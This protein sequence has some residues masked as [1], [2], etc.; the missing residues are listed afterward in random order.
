MSSLRGKDF[1]GNRSFGPP[2]EATHVIAPREH[3]GTR[4]D[5]RVRCRR[6][7]PI[8]AVWPRTPP[9]PTIQRLPRPAVAAQ[10]PA[11]LL[12]SRGGSRFVSAN[13]R[14]SVKE[15]HRRMLRARMLPANEDRLDLRSPSARDIGL[16]T[17]AD[18]PARPRVACCLEGAA[19]RVRVRLLVSDRG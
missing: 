5:N 10:E 7:G 3:L 9:F 11:G 17:V 4:A 16:E 1:E 14:R 13:D 2:L 15:T 8:S 19:I 6:A 12:G 18:H